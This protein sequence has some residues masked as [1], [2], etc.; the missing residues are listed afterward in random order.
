MAANELLGT[1]LNDHLAGATAGSQL[2]QKMAAENTGTELGA[3]LAE[4]SRDIEEDRTTLEDLMER[5]GIEK[6]PAKEAAGWLIEKVSRLKLSDRFSGSSDLKLLLELESLGIGIQGKMM[7]W[8]ALQEA[9][10]GIPELAT[11]D[12]AG[13]AKRADDQRATVEGHRRET[14]RRALLG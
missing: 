12:L 13:L 14:A 9:S 8:Q 5:L 3:Y 10:D 1:Y 7:M 2:A 4:L 6:N 11:L